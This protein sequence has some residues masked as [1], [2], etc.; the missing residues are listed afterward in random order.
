ML[1]YG[2]PNFKLEKAIIDRRIAILE[3]EGIVFKTNV[4]VGV[5]YSIKQLNTFDAVVLC[6]GATEGRSIPTRGFESKGVVQAMTFLTQQTKALYGEK[7]SNQI[8]AKGKNVIVIGGGDTGSDCVGTSNRQGAKTVTNFEILPKP[9]A[10]RSETT[11]WPFWP[12]QLKTSSSHEEGCDRNWLI[13][14][15]EFISNEKGELTGLKTVEVVWK[16]TLGQRPELIEKEGSEKIW[17]CELALLAL[18]FTGP[19]KTLSDQ[20]GIEIDLRNN[21]KAKNYQTNIPNIFTAGDMRRGQSLIV[22]AISEGRE[23]AREVD[24]YLMGYTNLPTKGNGDLPSL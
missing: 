24:N 3:A 14:T 8:S 23:A 18:G 20:L 5:N 2:I 16:M 13:N 19:E 21:Y 12:L 7:I 1:R 11:P 6:G 15:K 10:S 17:P 4:N 22:W 9:P